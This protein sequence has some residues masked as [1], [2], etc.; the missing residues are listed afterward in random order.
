MRIPDELCSNFFLDLRAFG[1]DFDR[2]CDRAKNQLGVRYIRSFIS[3]TYEMPGTRNLR[4]VY[5]ET[6]K[7]TQLIS[8]DISPESYASLRSN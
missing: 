1:K 8:P 3:R 5:A 6:E 7:G 2:Y 4:V